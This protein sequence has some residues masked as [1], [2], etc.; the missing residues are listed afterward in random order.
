VEAVTVNDVT[1][2]PST[3]AG[4]IQ[5]TVAELEPARAVTPVGG[6]ALDVAAD[7][8]QLN[9]AHIRSAAMHVIV[10]FIWPP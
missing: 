8:E 9:M 5:W 1:G 2:A 3:V 7:A 4:L 10:R 6:S